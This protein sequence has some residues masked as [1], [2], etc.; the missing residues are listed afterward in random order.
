MTTS[1]RYSLVH[2]LLAALGRSKQVSTNNFDD[3]YERA[4]LAVT[5]QDI[6]FVLT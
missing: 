4:V 3:L 5:G 6:P 1:R 2:V